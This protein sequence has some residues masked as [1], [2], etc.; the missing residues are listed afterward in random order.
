MDQPNE[1]SV[2]LELLADLL[3]GVWAHYAQQKGY[4]EERI[5]KK[6]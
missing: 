5:L 3:A 1:L 2:K 4:L 6:P